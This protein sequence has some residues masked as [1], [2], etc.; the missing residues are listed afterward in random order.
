M[1]WLRAKGVR[2]ITNAAL[3]GVDGNGLRIR[4]GEGLVE[5]IPSHSI[6]V[7]TRQ[8][9]STALADALRGRVP[10]VH[11]VGSANGAASSLIVHAISEGRAVGVKL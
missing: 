10:E 7:L 5:V 9:P 4:N 11:V 2:I 1:A 6:L 8:T 3:A